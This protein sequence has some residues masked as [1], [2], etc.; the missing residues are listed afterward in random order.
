MNIDTSIY[1]TF[2]SILTNLADLIPLK[3]SLLFRIFMIV[4]ICASIL[5]G[6]ASKSP[7]PNA[8]EQI[9]SLQSRINPDFLTDEWPAGHPVNYDSVKVID[10]VYVINRKGVYL[11]QDPD[12][13]CTMMGKADFGTSIQVIEVLPNWYGVLQ[14]IEREDVRKGRHY[15]IWRWEK[16]Y[17]PIA[18]TGSFNAIRITN[19]DLYECYNNLDYYNQYEKV[20]LK[21][22]MQQ[23]LKVELISESEF[24]L[25]QSTKL[26]F[27]IHDTTTI[28]K[29]DGAFELPF[30][31]GIKQFIDMPN[32]GDLSHEH[33]YIG[34]YTEINWYVVF[35][36]YFEGSSYTLYNMN[37]SNDSIRIYG[38]PYLSVNKKHIISFSVLP[39]NDGS[40]LQLFDVMPDGKLR[41]QFAG[42]MEFWSPSNW[43]ESIFMGSDGCFYTPVEHRMLP[44][45]LT[46]RLD[47]KNQYLKITIL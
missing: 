47:F 17:V 20:S 8:A 43:G 3:M 5:S 38:Y 31:N 12:E 26:D 33:Y 34:R 25:K 6:C 14:R 15:T 29:V 19:E 44:W 32:Y 37:N 40:T 18:E 27:L 36:S 9:L 41:L 28:V 2:D 4:L 13:N 46:S 30:F 7:K 45:D 24:N 11:K 35:T 23:H 21:D 39:Y 1:L 42:A 16:V 22:E 10:T